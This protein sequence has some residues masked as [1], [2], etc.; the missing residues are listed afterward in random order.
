M[1]HGVTN[2]KIQNTKGHPKLKLQ[3]TV[4]HRT[5]MPHTRKKGFH[6]TV[7][8]PHADTEHS[9]TPSQDP[10][11]GSYM[12]MHADDVSPGPS[13]RRARMSAAHRQLG[14]LPTFFVLPLPLPL[15]LP[16]LLRV[17]G[18]QLDIEDEVC[19]WGDGASCICSNTVH[20]TI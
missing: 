1:T 7:A 2:T 16:L 15:P 18:Y 5:T 17:D 10:S 3:T 14:G 20:S 13:G 12:H 19:V 4:A 9:Q 11:R 8:S 6:A